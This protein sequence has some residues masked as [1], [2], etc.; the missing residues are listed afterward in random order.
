MDESRQSPRGPAVTVAD[1]SLETFLSDV[2]S[3]RVA[4]SAGAVTAVT[5]ALAASL[6][7]MVCLHTPTA[8]TSPRLEAARTELAARR[9][10]LL[11]LA[12]D[13]AA[14][15]ETVQTAFEASSDEDHGQAALGRATEA[16]LQIAVAARDVAEA[17]V[18]VA[19]EG[20]Q[21]ARTDAVV[22]AYLARAAVASAAA[23]VRENVELLTDRSF[24]ADARARIETAEADAEAAVT[25]ITDQSGN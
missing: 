13:D 14:A 20:T 9:G 3:S 1:Q 2:A 18:V 12:G 24:V 10:R 8:E 7:E 16:P 19:S 11:E 5:G 15:V 23:I 22:G 6:C 4:P 21:N 17:A 25:A